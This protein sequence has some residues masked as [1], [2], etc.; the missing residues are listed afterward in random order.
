MLAKKQILFN[1][2]LTSIYTKTQVDNIITLTNFYKKTSVDLSLNAKQKNKPTSNCEHVISRNWLKYYLCFLCSTMRSPTS[3]STICGP[4]DVASP[5][6]AVPSLDYAVDQTGR[7]GLR[8]RSDSLT[9]ANPAYS[10]V[11]AVD[12]L[13]VKH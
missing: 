13:H 1:P 4:E 11:D 10:T 6:S 3:Q 9:R 5:Y 7:L 8:R 12:G 2:D